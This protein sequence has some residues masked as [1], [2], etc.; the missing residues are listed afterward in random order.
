M[1]KIVDDVTGGAL[2]AFSTFMHEETI[3]NFS[4][5]AMLVMPARLPDKGSGG[6]SDGED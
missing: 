3:R 6:S 4:K 2:N 1:Q 5:T